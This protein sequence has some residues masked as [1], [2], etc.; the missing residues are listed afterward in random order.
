MSFSGYKADVEFCRY[1][2]RYLIETV[3]RLSADAA[4]SRGDRESFRYG[5]A[6][7]LQSRMKRMVV[8]QK[9]ADEAAKAQQEYAG[10]MALVLVDAKRLAVAAHFGEQ[11]TKKCN[12]RDYDGMQ[13][14]GH[15]AGSKLN[16]PTARPLGNT[17]ATVREIT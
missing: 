8:E 15:A 4:T 2:Y 7:T 6:T 14:L 13:A 17:N 12:S 5:A 3:Y 11:G 10:T 9:A 16:I 1:L